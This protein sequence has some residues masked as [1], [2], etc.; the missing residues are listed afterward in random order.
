MGGV[1]PSLALVAHAGQQ[2]NPGPRARVRAAK[3]DR[4]TDTETH[5]PSII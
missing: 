5:D 3:T 1:T 4:Q 2:R